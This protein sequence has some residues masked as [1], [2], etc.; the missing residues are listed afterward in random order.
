MIRPMKSLIYPPGMTKTTPELKSINKWTA[1]TSQP[2]QTATSGLKFPGMK[3]G[4][5]D[6]TR[7][8]QTDFMNL[9]K[10]KLNDEDLGLKPNVQKKISSIFG[11][12]P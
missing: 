6:P 12:N 11:S 4:A 5:N 8:K 7:P 3:A 10:M 1:Q 9:K 2:S